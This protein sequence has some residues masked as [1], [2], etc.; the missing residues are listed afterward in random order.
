MDVNKPAAVFLRSICPRRV[1][2]AEHSGY[3]NFGTSVGSNCLHVVGSGILTCNPS[4]T[5]LVI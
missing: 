4:R 5:C 3:A 1:A 2:L